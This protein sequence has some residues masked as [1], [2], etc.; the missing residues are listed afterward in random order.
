MPLRPNVR[1]DS[2]ILPIVTIAHAREVEIKSFEG[3]GFVIAPEVFVTCWHCVRS[4]LDRDTHYYAL[5]PQDCASGYRGCILR[6]I[7]QHPDGKD[8]AIA[9]IDHAPSAGFTIAETLP[10]MGTDVCSFGYPHSVMCRKPDGGLNLNLVG[11]HLGGYITR[12]FQDEDRGYGPTDAYEIDMPTP[13]GLSGAPLIVVG[14]REIAGV[15][16]GSNEVASIKHYGR[17]QADGSFEAEVQR[18]VTFGLAHF[19]ATLRSLSGPATQGRV[20]ADY[21]QS[22]S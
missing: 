15:I 12:A 9:N 13:E 4:S 8:L 17:I 3:T 20:L 7:S 10:V 16:Y 2:D 11:R 5:V 22:L 18:V 1:V 21:L 14:S 19:T 6:N